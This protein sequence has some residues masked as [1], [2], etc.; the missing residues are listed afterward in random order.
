VD[1]AESAAWMLD[2]RAFAAAF[3]PQNNGLMSA[4][5]PTTVGRR[6]PIT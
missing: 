2:F 5:P 6:Y 4:A 1:Y 3:A